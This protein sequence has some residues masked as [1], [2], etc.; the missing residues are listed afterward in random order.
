M[1]CYWICLSKKGGFRTIA[2][3]PSLWR[4]LMKCLGSCWKE[5]DKTHALEEDSAVAGRSATS[6]IYG[7]AVRRSVELARGRHFT[8]ILWDIASFYERVWSDTLE[9]N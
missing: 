1:K 3:F 4:V 5:Y 2:T 6:H 7:R 9:E 8:I